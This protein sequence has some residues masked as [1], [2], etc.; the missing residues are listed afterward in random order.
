MA[1]SISL[2]KNT[3]QDVNSI[4]LVWIKFNLQVLALKNQRHGT[5]TAVFFSSGPFRKTKTKQVFKRSWE[6]FMPPRD[7]LFLTI[8]SAYTPRL[9]RDSNRHK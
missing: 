9:D 7:L 1:I 8:E 2:L 6:A 4:F 5:N 3:V